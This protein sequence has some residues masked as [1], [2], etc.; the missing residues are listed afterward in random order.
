MSKITIAVPV[1]GVE[2]YIERCARSLFEQTYNDIEYLFVDDH[3][4]DRSIDVLNYTLNDYPNRKNHVRIIRHEK[5]RGLAAARNTGV[6][7][8]NGE[9]ILWVDS[10]DY[11]EK[12][13]IEECIKK[14][15]EGDYDIVLFDMIKH[16]PKR[17]IPKRNA[18]FTD[19]MDLTKK[20][21]NSSVDHGVCGKLIR[22][23]LYIDNNIRTIEGVNMAEDYMVTPKLAYCA[24]RVAQIHQYFYHYDLTN[25]NS[26]QNTF[27]R[28]R[29]ENQITVFE[30]LELFFKDEKE[31][32][33]MIHHQF[34]IS[35]N[36]HVK[37][38][39]RDGDDEFYRM[40]L[41]KLESLDQSFICHLDLGD[42]LFYYLH[43]D[44][45][46]IVYIKI[47]YYIKRHKK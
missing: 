27:S 23:S 14:Q 13:T 35:V 31:L 41:K 36:N 18:D 22:K 29:C 45:L 32:L 15:A 19:H 39:M 47:A 17:D 2:K 37:H 16:L 9:F 46:R 42:K 3:T 7:N 4:P 5:N 33:K 11:I 8:A 28:K 12:N 6:E 40:S 20:L 34:I 1:Y 21:I 43:Y 24:K 44:I 30:N 38:G 25:Q 26:Y 10:D